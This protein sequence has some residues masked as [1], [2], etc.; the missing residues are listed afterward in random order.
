ME[1]TNSLPHKQIK[2]IRSFNEYEFSNSLSD[3]LLRVL[4]IVQKLL[5][6][7]RHASKRDIYYMHPSVFSGKSEL[8]LEPISDDISCYNLKM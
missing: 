5:Q 4:L 6:E 7:N 3:V 8:I 1:Y 2:L